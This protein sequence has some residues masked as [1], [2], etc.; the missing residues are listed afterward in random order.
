MNIMPDNEA[1]NQA[2]AGF[3]Q[4]LKIEFPDP[5]AVGSQT[6]PSFTITRIMEAVMRFVFFACQNRILWSNIGNW[7]KNWHV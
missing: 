1:V 2:L 3:P 6:F 4:L 7:T 5:L